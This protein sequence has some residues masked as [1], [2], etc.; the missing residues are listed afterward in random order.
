MELT[1]VS[2]FVPVTATNLIRPGFEETLKAMVAETSVVLLILLERTI[3]GLVRAP[4]VIAPSVAVPLSMSDSV[5]L[6]LVVI[7]IVEEL[8]GAAA[9]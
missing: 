9:F 1:A 2:K 3:E 8:C 5:L 7:V 6:A 4:A